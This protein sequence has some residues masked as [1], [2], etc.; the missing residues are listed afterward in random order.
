V[1]QLIKLNS[2]NS[3]GK[4]PNASDGD[5]DYGDGGDDG[6]GDDNDD[7]DDDDDYDDV[8]DED[9]SN[10]R[11]AISFYQLRRILI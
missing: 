8:N 11:G 3:S 1:Y 6:G 9:G 4:H 2:I 10:Y 5:G 7:D